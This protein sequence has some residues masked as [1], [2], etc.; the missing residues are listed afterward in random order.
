[1]SF[2]LK[3]NF[4]VTCLCSF[5]F[6]VTFLFAGCGSDKESGVDLPKDFRQVAEVANEKVNVDIYFDA[7]VSMK[8]YTTL[9]A[10]N[11][12]RTL[13]DIFTDIGSSMGEIRFYKF[14]AEI[15]ELQNRDYRK[16]SSPEPYNEKITAVQNVIDKSDTNH[17]SVIVTD[18]FESDSDWSNISKKIREKYF[19]NHQAVAIIA[20]KNSFNGDIFDVGLNAAKFNYNSYDYPDRFRPF[21]ILVMGQESSINKFMEKFKERQTLPNETNYLLLS[22]NLASSTSNF[23]KLPVSDLQNFYL[24]DTLNLEDKGVR[25]FGADNFNEPASFSVQFDYNPQLGACPLNFNEM[26]SD[27]KIFALEED[28]VDESNDENKDDAE[29]KK[30]EKKWQPISSEGVTVTINPVEGQEKTFTVNVS[31]SPEKNLREDRL[32]FVHIA[33]SP[34]DKGY[35]L[36]EW[37][38]AWNMANVD[39]SQA[40]F[41]G[42]KTINLIHVIGSL[43]DSVFAAAHPSLIN[44]N[45]VVDAR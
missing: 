39:V 44:I 40:N 16:Y 20:I 23:A 42:S 1:M 18:L 2:T 24:N 33:F 3:K 28:E 45:F 43:K 6:I 32:N 25:E 12:Y 37:V 8:G 41:D 21:Y 38:S 31:I 29:E 5:F 9:S 17:L 13:P 19:S 22:E 4:G 7:T 10:G 27:V 36:P 34:S 15:A 11:V 26:V 14:G 30:S 35:L